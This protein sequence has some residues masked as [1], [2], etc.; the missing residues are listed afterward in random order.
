VESAAG[1]PPPRQQ[2]NVILWVD[3]QTPFGGAVRACGVMNRPCASAARSDAL[4]PI[5]CLCD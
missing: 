3:G 4:W 1:G 5:A 2:T